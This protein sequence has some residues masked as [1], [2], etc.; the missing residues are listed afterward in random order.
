MF[1]SLE[2]VERPEVPTVMQLERKGPLG[3]SAYPSTAHPKSGAAAQAGRLDRQGRFKILGLLKQWFLL[4]ISNNG[5]GGA[6]RYADVQMR[7]Q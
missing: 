6:L 1:G 7:E 2:L 5:W 4:C 3:Q